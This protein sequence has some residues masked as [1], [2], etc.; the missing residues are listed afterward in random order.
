MKTRCA[1][2]PSSPVHLERRTRCAEILKARA[3][4]ALCL[5]GRR[6]V[7]APRS[8]RDPRACRPDSYASHS[9]LSWDE[10]T[11]N[12]GRRLRREGSMNPGLD[13]AAVIVRAD[14]RT[15][16]AS[17]CDADKRTR[18]AKCK[19]LRA[20]PDVPFGRPRVRF[21]AAAAERDPEVVYFWA[22]VVR[23]RRIVAPSAIRC[24]GA[25]GEWLVV[26]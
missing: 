13:Y 7:S 9:A 17:L 6:D 24:E 1:A 8:P 11:R 16:T 4:A 10:R 26:R 12:S 23:A 15:P 14:Q 5:P 21:D 22:P 3:T 20:A 18:C 25:R 19:N 2:D